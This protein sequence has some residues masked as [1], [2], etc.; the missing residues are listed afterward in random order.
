MYAQTSGDDSSRPHPVSSSRVGHDGVQ[1]HM[2]TTN[3]SR[4]S[5]DDSSTASTSAHLNSD[6]LSI[7]QPIGYSAS[8]CGYCA[9]VKGMRSDKKGGRS[10]GLV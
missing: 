1:Q 8:Q 7:L 5:F 6:P 3:S 4:S 10:Y 2:A 9:E